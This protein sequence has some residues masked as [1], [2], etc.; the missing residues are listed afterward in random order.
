MG[1]RLIMKIKVL[2]TRGKIKS[3][4]PFHSNHSGILFDDILMLDLGEKKYLDYK[5]RWIFL[6]HLHPDHASFIV[7][8]YTT[9]IPIYAPE[10]SN[11]PRVIVATK[12][13]QVGHYTVTPIPT[14][15]S[16]KVQSQAY[17][18]SDNKQTLLY[19]GDMI[20]IDK[21][22]HPMIGKVDL[23]IT[24]ASY[25][26]K[27]RMIRKDKQTGRLYG[28]TGIPDLI[29]FFKSFI[30]HIL[31]VHFGSWFYQDIDKAKRQI[32]QLGKENQII[33]HISY[34]GLELNL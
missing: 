30:Q 25:V 16:A 10:P 20:W 7:D 3:S 9:D 22:Y 6:T 12:A 34:D 2:G 18:I 13:V 17:L 33:I 32:L 8:P 4:A 29:R 1:I 26:R 24:E 5:P 28:H 14:H 27:G 19:T 11:G 31:F 21:K 15:H 23:V